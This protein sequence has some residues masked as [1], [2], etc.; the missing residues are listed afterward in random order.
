[1]INQTITWLHTFLFPV[2]RTEKIQLNRNLK[3][4]I[5]EKKKI[6][7]NLNKKIIFKEARILQSLYKTAIDLGIQA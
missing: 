5:F 3:T 6:I 2:S 1:M 4:G 7:T